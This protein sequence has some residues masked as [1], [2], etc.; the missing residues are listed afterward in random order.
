MRRL[1]QGLKEGFKPCQ[2]VTILDTDGLRFP[3]P[4]PKEFP[5]LPHQ[6]A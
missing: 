1:L 3:A 4:F 2:V 5:P 6:N